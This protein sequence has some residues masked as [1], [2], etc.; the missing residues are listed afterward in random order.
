M[1]TA[2]PAGKVLQGQD[3]YTSTIQQQML[4]TMGTSY[5]P[6]LE[7]GIGKKVILAVSSGDEKWEYSGILKD[8]TTEFITIMDTEYKSAVDEAPRKADIIV[9]RALG[10][11]RHL[12]E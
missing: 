11:V 12:G 6:M 8:Y 1:K 9:P 5:E 4:T 10:V 7:K 2:S 3:K